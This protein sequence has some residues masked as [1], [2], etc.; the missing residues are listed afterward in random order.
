MRRRQNVKFD[1]VEEIKPNT[2]CTYLG[3]KIDQTGDNKTGIKHR[4]NQ[5]RKAIN[6]IISIQCHKDIT[7]KPKIIYL[8]NNN[9][10]HADVWGR[11]TANTYQRN[12]Q[13]GYAK[14]ISK[15]TKDR[16]NEK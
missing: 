12:I 7:K 4:I 2:E 11:S 6:Y 13:N 14:E 8:P 10:E 3:T 16:K 15:K 9:S 1:S 5:T